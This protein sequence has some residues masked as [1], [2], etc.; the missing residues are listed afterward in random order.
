MLSLIL[1]VICCICD[2]GILPVFIKGIYCSISSFITYHIPWQPKLVVKP[3]Y[4][5]NFTMTVWWFPANETIDLSEND[6]I[7]GKMNLSE[8]V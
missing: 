5:I 6:G 3:K 4:K 8:P 2:A 1:F 7:D